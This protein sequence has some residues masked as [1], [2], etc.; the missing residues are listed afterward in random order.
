MK[1]GEIENH[2]YAL[3]NLHMQLSGKL[4]AC[5]AVNKKLLEMIKLQQ[6]GKL[7]KEQITSIDRDIDD[8]TNEHLAN[9]L[10][11]CENILEVFDIT[12]DGLL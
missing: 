11:E 5:I 6:L 8:L 7:S 3:H 12:K 10:H 2:I 9:A 1:K 4:I